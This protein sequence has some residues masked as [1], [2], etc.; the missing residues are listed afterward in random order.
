MNHRAWNLVTERLPLADSMCRV[1][2]HDNN[3]LHDVFRFD[4]GYDFDYQFVADG[5]R[6]P[7]FWSDI[8]AWQYHSSDES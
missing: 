8:W 3:I 7:A 2:T 6:Y 4:A 5:I 1:M